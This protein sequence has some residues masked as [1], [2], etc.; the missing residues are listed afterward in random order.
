M[1]LFYVYSPPEVCIDRF[2]KEKSGES[3]RLPIKIT[4]NMKK[5]ILFAAFI[6]AVS[7]TANAQ[8]VIKKEKAKTCCKA[9]KAECKD[10]KACCK[11]AAKMEK[12]EKKECKAACKE[13][14]KEAKEACKDAKACSK[15]CQKDCKKACKDAKGEV[16]KE[17][18]G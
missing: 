1:L 9:E 3:N 14:C 6:A 13:A 15:Q 7:F 4:T 2:F 17:V 8:T 12:A 5:I 16:K 11:D 18:K 10:A